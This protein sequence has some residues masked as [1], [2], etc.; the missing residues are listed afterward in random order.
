MFL[1]VMFVALALAIPSALA[2]NITNE[3]NNSIPILLPNGTINTTAPV[4][5]LVPTENVVEQPAVT[6][7]EPNPKPADEPQ[8]IE[9]LELVVAPTEPRDA[10]T[11]DPATVDAPI[12]YCGHKSC[13][14]EILTTVRVSETAFGRQE[15]LQLEKDP[16]YPCTIEEGGFVVCEPITPQGE[17]AL[18]AAYDLSEGIPTTDYRQ[19]VYEGYSSQLSTGI[20]RGVRIGSYKRSTINPTVRQR[21]EINASEPGVFVVGFASNVFVVSDFNYGT[22]ENCSIG[23]T[24]V[25]LENYHSTDAAQALSWRFSGNGLDSSGN[26][27]TATFGGAAYVN[28]TFADG[29]AFND[30]NK[31]S[32]PDAASLDIS[33]MTLSFWVRFKSLTENQTLIYRYTSTNG[34]LCEFAKY[35]TTGIQCYTRNSTAGG[36]AWVQTGGASET[37]NPD[38]EINKWYHIVLTYNLSSGNL[39]I[40]QDGTLKHSKIATNHSMSSTASFKWGAD[41]FDAF[42]GTVDE[43]NLYSRTFSATEVTSLYNSG[44]YLVN[45]SYGNYTSMIDLGQSS[46]VS[47][48]SWTGSGNLTI[49]ARTGDYAKPGLTDTGLFGYWP[50]NQSL[51]C[52]DANSRYNGTASSGVICGNVSGPFVLENATWFDSDTDKITLPLATNFTNWS[53]Q[54][55]VRSDGTC[56]DGQN[57]FAKG[58]DYRI[59]TTSSCGITIVSANSSGSNKSMSS[60]C[61]ISDGRWH[62]LAYVYND[63]A[64]TAYAYCDGVQKSSVTQQG[65]ATS[66]TNFTIGGGT[67]GLTFRG[68]VAQVSLWN[69]TLAPADLVAW[70]TWSSTLT[71]G[72]DPGLTDGRYVQYSAILRTND[73]RN[74]SMLTSVSVG[75]SSSCSLSNGGYNVTLMNGAS[76]GSGYATLDGTDDRI[77]TDL[78]VSSVLNN[79]SFTLAMWVKSDVDS[80]QRAFWSADSS[81]TDRFYLRQSDISSNQVVLGASSWNPVL[82]GYGA[83]SNWTHYVLIINGTS[84]LFYRNGLNVANTTGI[85]KNY[86]GKYLRFGAN[87]DTL[88]ETHDGNIDGINLYNRALTLTEVSQLYTNITVTT[89]QILSIEFNTCS[90]TTSLTYDP[91]GNMVYDGTYTYEYDSFNRLTKIWLGLANTTNVSAYLYDDEGIRIRKIEYN[92]TSGAILSR[93]YYPDDDFV[94]VYNASNQTTDEVYYRVDGTLLAQMKGNN[95]TFIH[96]NHLG[97]PDLVTSTTGSTIETTKLDPYGNDITGGNSRY[98]FTGHERDTETGLDYMK[99]RHYSPDLAMFVQPDS[100]LEDIYSPQKLNRYAYVSNRP[101]IYTD[102]TGQYSCDATGGCISFCVGFICP[103]MN[104]VPD[105]GDNPDVGLYNGKNVRFANQEQNAFMSAVISLTTMGG[106]R[107]FGLASSTKVT[108]NNAVNYADLPEDVQNTLAKVKSGE[109][110]PYAKDG[111]IYQNRNEALPKQAANYY[112]EYTVQADPAKGRGTNRL[113]VGNNG[114]TYYTTNHYG[115]FKRVTSEPDRTNFNQAYKMLQRAVNRIGGNK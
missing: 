93:T 67:S 46:T 65:T 66:S 58:W 104:A 68:S 24:Q 91:N 95:L 18:R 115:S 5:I 98:V 108:G 4:I 70:N 112:R 88:A 13:A 82:T 20:V 2:D 62:S 30:A 6:I 89:G 56:V 25:T 110:L 45:P 90:A 96:T 52:K 76:T 1:A 109:K 71:S 74:T 105:E 100:L 9:A 106:V 43:I 40:Y 36:A 37:Q 19:P 3:T 54:V 51:L 57:I 103:I 99:A 86:P 55:W 83:L 97:T 15:I 64:K 23:T 22:C 102:P 80:G 72:N 94:R 114:E 53:V 32:A 61:S 42:N 31:L 39:S 101:T 34:Y 75:T 48:V 107:S 47:S 63:T 92:T 38:Y 28:N 60:V 14:K 10:P 33:N 11:R 17:A 81:G 113:V 87:G 50:L 59:Y 73:T 16:N 35:D 27:N 26:A 85:T 77:D 41:Y 21:F 12:P 79:G 8:V 84:G 49:A 29:F 7:S 111:T 69:K 44:L 78:N